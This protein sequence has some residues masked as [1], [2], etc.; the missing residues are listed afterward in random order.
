MLL[1][2][3]C[4]SV[5]GQTENTI[6]KD[7]EKIEGLEYTGE[8]TFYLQKKTQTILAYQSGKVKWK[9]AVVK[10]C[11]KPSVGKSEI[12]KIQIEDKH[13]KIVYGKHSFA[14]IEMETGKVVCEGED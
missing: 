6:P 5:F 10:I 14:R 4:F 7:F 2:L 13:L 8:I 3:T 12:R 11:G 9:E 1:L